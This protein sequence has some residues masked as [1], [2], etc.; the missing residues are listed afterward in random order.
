M[1]TW[2]LVNVKTD[3]VHLD[4]FSTGQTGI[5]PVLSLNSKF[6]VFRFRITFPIKTISSWNIVF[7]FAEQ[8]SNEIG[9]FEKRPF[10]SFFFFSFSSLRWSSMR[11]FKDPIE[12]KKFSP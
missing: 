1:M 4:C 5:E 8:K 2:S 10:S 6:P 12:M 9:D 11:D 3:I 7:D